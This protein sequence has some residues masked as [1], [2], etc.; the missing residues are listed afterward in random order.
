M[1]ARGDAGAGAAGGQASARRAG[2]PRHQLPPGR[3]RLRGRSVGTGPS[4]SRQ[5]PA[6]SSFWGRMAASDSGARARGR[7]RRRPRDRRRSASRRRWWSPG[8]WTSTRSR[9]PSPMIPR[10]RL[11]YE[12]GL[13]RGSRP[14]RDGRLS[15]EL[16]DRRPGELGAGRAG[17]TPGSG[18]RSRPLGGRGPFGRSSTKPALPVLTVQKYGSAPVLAFVE[19]RP[20]LLAPTADRT[21][22]LRER[23]RPPSATST[24]PRGSPRRRSCPVRAG[25]R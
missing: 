3:G 15:R 2:E 17:R 16:R 18:T 20:K 23:L 13:A 7:G 24:T 6:R 19:P 21:L 10:S 11:S 25:R 8:R 5:S 1:G 12:G 22:R 9:G 4:R 14:A